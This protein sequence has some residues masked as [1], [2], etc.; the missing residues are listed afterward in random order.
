MHVCVCLY[1]G[2]HIAL[3]KQID[4]KF[5]GSDKV[6]PQRE[7]EPVVV[8]AEDHDEICLNVW[9]TCSAMFLLVAVGWY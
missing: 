5:G 1:F 8:S 2:C 3:A 7:G 4:G 9:I 6:A